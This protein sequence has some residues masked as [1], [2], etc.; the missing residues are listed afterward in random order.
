MVTFTK[1]TALC[2]SR[3]Q[4]R[5]HPR[6]WMGVDGCV[7]HV[8]PYVGPFGVPVHF[9][10]SPEEVESG[11]RHREFASCQYAPEYP[12]KLSCF[13]LDLQSPNSSV[14]EASKEEGWEGKVAFPSF[15]NEGGDGEGIEKLF[16]IIKDSSS[17]AIVENG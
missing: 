6:G 4:T 12:E 5:C 7:I 11:E 2:A 15:L 14:L 13:P 1:V 10:I 3:L 17:V 16:E 8:A 9:A